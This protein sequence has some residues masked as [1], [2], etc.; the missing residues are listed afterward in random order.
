MW[1]CLHCSVGPTFDP[2]SL[3]TRERPGTA[4]RQFARERTSSFPGSPF[5]GSRPCGISSIATHASRAS[6]AS[7]ATGTTVALGCGPATLS[8]RAVSSSV[9]C[10]ATPF[11][12]VGPQTKRMHDHWPHY[13]FA[14]R[15]LWPRR[16]C[17]LDSFESLGRL[18]TDRVCV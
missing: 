15:E 13:S 10:R 12:R 1:S 17:C 11:C 18:I 4:A 14:S 9:G 2:R 3:G 5:L 6:G 16:A 7:W 8:S